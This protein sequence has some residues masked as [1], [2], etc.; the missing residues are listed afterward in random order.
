MVQQ[1]T[2]KTWRV[3]ETG[4]DTALAD[5]QAHG[6]A[7][8][9]LHVTRPGH[10]LV[11]AFFLLVASRFEEEE[12]APAQPP[13]QGSIGIPVNAEV[14]AAYHAFPPEEQAALQVLLSG[15]IAR[16]Y[17]LQERHL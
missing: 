12:A 16:Y 17:N 15:M 2:W 4:L 13:E 11:Q 14:W 5:M 9:A 7:F 3:D 8:N 6:W 1:L 10:G